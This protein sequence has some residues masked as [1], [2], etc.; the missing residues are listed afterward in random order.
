MD[1]CDEAFDRARHHSE[2]RRNPMPESGRTRGFGA[3]GRTRSNLPRL[4]AQFGLILL[5]NQARSV[6]TPALLFYARLVSVLV[7]ADAWR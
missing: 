5:G 7:S 2:N 6:I 3:G 4:R 1:R